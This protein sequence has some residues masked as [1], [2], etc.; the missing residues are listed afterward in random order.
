LW[1]DTEPMRER[2]RDYC[3]IFLGSTDPLVKTRAKR[4]LDNW[5]HLFTFLLLVSPYS[6]A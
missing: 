5:E 2:M 4:T 3:E 6:I 1:L